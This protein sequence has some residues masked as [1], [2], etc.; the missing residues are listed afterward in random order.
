MKAEVKQE[1]PLVDF[2]SEFA[3]NEDTTETGVWVPYMGGTEFLVAYSKNRK[4]RNRASYYYKKYARTLDAN[5][6]QARDKLEEITI[7]V[8]AETVLLGWRGPVAYQGIPLEYS[9]AN[10]KLLLTLLGVSTN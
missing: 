5:N 6:E 2:F 10:A 1:L 3:L 7:Q 9:V 8:M 4:F